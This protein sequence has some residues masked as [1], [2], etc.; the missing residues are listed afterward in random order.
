V[1]G[2]LWLLCPEANR[3]GV[4]DK[5]KHLHK[6]NKAKL[7]FGRAISMV[8]RIY[9]ILG[10]FHMDGDKAQGDETFI[11]CPRRPREIVSNTVTS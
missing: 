9:V 7:I 8:Q 4:D 5:K 11:V 6:W 1:E 3:D 10:P 2:Q